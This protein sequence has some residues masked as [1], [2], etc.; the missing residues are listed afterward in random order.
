M[1]EFLSALL[2]ESGELLTH[3]ML[4]SHSDLVH[5]FK[6]RDDDLRQRFA[7]IELTPGNNWLDPDTWAWRLDEPTRPDWLT[8]DAEAGAARRL[9][10]RARRMILSGGEHTLIVDGCWIVGGSALVRDVRAGRIL[11]V[12]DSATVRDVWGSATVQDVRGSATVQDV[13]GS[14]TVQDVWGSATVRDVGPLV[15][16]DD[17][18]KAHLIDGTLHR[19]NGNG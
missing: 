16:L 8:E 1:C 3:P 14:A 18:A 19:E 17:S 13:R 6:I 4:D 11:R 5:Y 15:T 7:K 2:L 12:Q 10:D 9:R